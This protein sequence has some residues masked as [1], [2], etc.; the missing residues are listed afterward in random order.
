MGSC[1]LEDRAMAMK[2]IDKYRSR[3]N[4]VVAVPMPDGRW[5]IKAAFAHMTDAQA[6]F[7]AIKANHPDAELIGASVWEARHVE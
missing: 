1:L 4:M 6:A 2:L 7:P 3:C 5:I